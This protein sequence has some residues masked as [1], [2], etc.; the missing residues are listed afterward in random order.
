MEWTVTSLVM[1]TLC[2]LIFFLTI[3]LILVVS[4]L[5]QRFANWLRERVASWRGRRLARQAG[6]TDPAVAQK[7]M[8]EESDAG[9]ES[10]YAD[11][12]EDKVEYSNGLGMCDG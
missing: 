2:F 8:E 1:H 9:A 10:G 3:D 7:L 4:G 11:S 5:K 6:E 12:V